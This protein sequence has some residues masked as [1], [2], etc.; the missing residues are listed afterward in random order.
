[1]KILAISY[2]FPNCYYPTHGIFVLNRLK[3]VSRH[4]DLKVINPIPWFPFCDYFQRYKNYKR[5]PK[6]E[7]IAGIEVFHPR[8]FII[9]KYF[10]ILDSISFSFAVVTLS[11]KLRKAFK[12]DT[13]DLH[14]TYPD[15]LSGYILS[16]VVNRKKIISIRGKEALYPKTI[17]RSRM[18]KYLLPKFDHIVTLSKELKQCCIDL[19]ASAEKISII[20]NG[21][22]T[23]VF[24]FMEMMKC[25]LQ[26]GLP[27]QER[28]ILSVG[29][30]IYRKGFDRIISCLPKILTAFP[31]VKLHIIGSE[32]P[33]GDYRGELNDLLRE[34]NLKDKVVF[35]GKVENRFL[36]LWYNASD[37]FVL[38]SRGEGSPNVLSEALSCGCPSIATNVGS[39]SEIMKSDFMGKISPNN[40]SSLFE[41]IISVLS[42]KFNRKEISASMHRYNWDWCAIKV[43]NIYRDK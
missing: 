26:L 28:I 17:I 24:R 4:C 31:D 1:M 8:F 21:V 10:K 9:P 42:S 5:I 38:A 16:K 43:M 14:W 7:I 2:L 40:D 23:S 36:P 29:S 13:I 3:A 39:V 33:E 32:G 18:I 41:A 37:V 12:F 22:D 15:I 30:L 11:I 35:N 19:G 34:Y 6:K 25:R 27:F 20:R